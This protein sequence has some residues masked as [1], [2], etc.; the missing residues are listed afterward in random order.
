KAGI[1]R[2]DFLAQI[3]RMRGIRGPEDQQIRQ[4][5]EL[6]SSRQVNSEQAF[7]AI[8][9]LI[10]ARTHMR[11]GGFAAAQ[12]DSIAG[13]MSN[14]ESAPQTLLLRLFQRTGGFENMAG[15]RAFLGV[16]RE[17][18]EVIGGS[19]PR[20][21]R[22]LGILERLINGVFGTLFQRGDGA[23]LIDQVLD[24][25]ERLVP[26]VVSVAQGMRSLFGPA[27]RTFSAMMPA[28]M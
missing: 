4:A 27:W 3:A 19:G 20:S 9:N 28:L 12:G 1:G 10:E 21:Q 5:M 7:N 26:V 25:M 13:V 11:L 22:L 6:V 2:G 23:T 15:G 14:L 16:L 17:L 18:N 8:G 24:V